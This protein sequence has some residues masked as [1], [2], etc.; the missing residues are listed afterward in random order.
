MFG[1]S[2]AATGRPAGVLT[3]AEFGDDGIAALAARYRVEFCLVGD[4]ETIPGTF[5]G[6]PEAG[7]I[8]QRL[9][10][11]GDTPLHSVLHELAHVVCMSAAR[12][13]QLERDAGGDDAEECAVCWLQ[14]AL[15]DELDGV[16][17]RRLMR[18]MDA[19]GYSFRLGGA[20]RWFAEDADDARHWLE[21]RGL[22]DAAGRSTFRLRGG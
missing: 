8:G 12:R 1:D 16:G 6:E 22:I 15:A 11:R 4:G 18:D 13:A 9:Y 14:I 7:I 3:L 19:W 17:R 5:W 21:R 10:A 2:D 20:E